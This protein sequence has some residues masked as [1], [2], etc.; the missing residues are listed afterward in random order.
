MFTFA[1][2]YH[3]TLK[4]WNSFINKFYI[5]MKKTKFILF[6]FLLV[7]T[8]LFFTSCDELIDDFTTIE[9][10]LED[11]IFNI[12]L[13]LDLNSPSNSSQ[14]RS[15]NADYVSFSGNSGPIN[16]QSEMFGNLQEYIDSPIVLL[17]SDVKIRIT[18]T[19]ESG[20]RVRD[21]TTTTTGTGKS[22]SYQKDGSID[23][24]EDFSDPELTKYVK[25][26]LLAI[27]DSKTV[28]IDIA[29]LTDIVPSEIKETDVTLVSIIPSLKAEIKLTKLKN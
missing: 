26:I 1:D 15:V 27:Q 17:V 24:G 16:L 19:S 8:P 13:E 20:T 11:V 18:T 29:G 2:N 25:E 22:L 5:L 21:F 12:P 28:S 9:V 7:C 4:I 23:M 14:L 10:P 6:S 3:T